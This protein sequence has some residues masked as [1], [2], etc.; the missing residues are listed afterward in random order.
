MLENNLLF[1]TFVKS[2]KA[3]TGS[4]G[5]QPARNIPINGNNYES[6]VML[7]SVLSNYFCYLCLKKL[8]IFLFIFPFS[9]GAVH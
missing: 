9:A 1:A 3:E 5:V 6:S 4:A 8:I 7:L 2:E